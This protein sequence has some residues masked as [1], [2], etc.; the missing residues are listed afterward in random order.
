M[1]NDLALIR[2]QTQF[3]TGTPAA[4]A[5]QIVEWFGAVQAQDF[6]G[7]L[8]AIGQRSERLTA[9]DVHQAIAERQIVRTWPLRGTIH[10]VPAA[11]IQIL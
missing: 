5:L 8:W 1:S 2:C 11:D 6:G 10:F 4:S 7:G 9:N 3:L